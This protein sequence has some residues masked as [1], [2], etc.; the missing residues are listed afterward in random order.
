M[1]QTLTKPPRL[2]EFVEAEQPT[3]PGP[4]VVVLAI[5]IGT[6]GA[7]VATEVVE[8]GGPAFDEQ[9]IAAARRFRFEPGEV[10]G[11]PAPVRIHYRYSFA[12]I[13]NSTAPK[14][15]ALAG[16]VMDEAGRPVAG[17]RVSLAGQ[18]S[19]VSTASDGR[20]ELRELSTGP[21]EVAARHADYVPVRSQV[22]VGP[23]RENAIALVLRRKRRD[24]DDE[25]VIRA[26][27]YLT[28]PAA[29]MVQMQDAT[30]IPGTQGD[31]LK[32]VQNLPGVASSATG[33]DR[34]VVWGAAPEDT[35]VVVDGVELPALYHLGG[36]RSTINPALVESIELV[37]GAFGAPFGRGLGGL[38]RVQTGTL[39]SSGLKGHVALD[40]LDASAA[41]AG[42]AGPR[43]RVFAASRLGH[44]HRVFPAMASGEARELFPVPR[45]RDAQ[46]KVEGELRP[47]ETLAVTLLHADDELEQRFD[48]RSARAERG[49]TALIA[50]Y[51]RQV[52]PSR[53]DVTPS[54]VS[55]RRAEELRFGETPASIRVDEARPGLRANF[56]RRALGMDLDAGLD[57]LVV[58]AQVSRRGS[59]TRPSREGDVRVFGQ[60]P[61]DD[62]TADDYRIAVADVGLYAQVGIEIGRLRLT[63]GVRADVLLLDGDRL[64]VPFG[65]A[66]RIG[67]TRQTTTIDPRIL[68]RFPLGRSA[69]VH[70]AAGVHHQPP[71]PETLSAA[72]GNPGLGPS[73]AL[74]LV[75]GTQHGITRTLTL[76]A[77][78]F[79][80]SFSSLVARNPLPNPALGEALTGEGKGRSFGVQLLLRRQFQAGLSGWL[81]YTLARSDRTDA[82]GLP[83]R[84]F[85]F[86][87]THV[88]TIN[89]TRTLGAW[90]FGGRFRYSSGYPRTPVTGAFLDT[91]S[92][93]Y[94]PLFGRHNSERLPDFAQLDLRV[95]RMLRLPV[96]DLALYLD[97]QNVG[98]RGNVSEVTYDFDFRQR[99]FIPALPMLAIAGARWSF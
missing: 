29:V 76:E 48:G 52:G 36:I 67:F 95:E 31:T 58:L 84:L 83:R 47:G 16:R 79:L 86:D 1:A 37:P 20:F 63:P 65:E 89:A 54:F 78:G 7:V 30:K 55:S 73:R 77:T 75:A 70:A 2:V 56:H 88:L 25:Q 42:Q 5:D 98:N 57:A 82:P 49:F 64:N 46:A 13:P 62:V 33:S 90:T 66:P 44:L 22:F 45:Y 21:Y 87:Q 12:A 6:D 17:A 60:P 19:W 28:Q 32:V 27:L 24:V 11:V 93:R 80:E 8:S 38:V 10:D 94:Q 92:G 23:E 50:S 72:F 59:L 91:R 18:N 39:P 43:L 69:S 61:G 85:D 14:S 96:G 71:P 51:R 53:V 99:R 68:A 81:S 74:H 34:L 3:E 26:S 35:R 97:L 40:L 4:S 41:V 9:A 15:F